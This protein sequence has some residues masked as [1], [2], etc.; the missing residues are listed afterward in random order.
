MRGEFSCEVERRRGNL[1]CGLLVSVKEWWWERIVTSAP[2]ST[3]LP[4]SGPSQNRMKTTIACAITSW[5]RH[6]SIPAAWVRLAPAKRTES[7]RSDGMPSRYDPELSRWATVA[8]RFVRGE[9]W[10]IS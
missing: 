10:A 6:K 4:P 5:G 2:N 7:S 8:N 1:L 9:G 3:K